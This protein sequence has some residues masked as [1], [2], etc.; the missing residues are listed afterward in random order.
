MIVGVH[1]LAGF[2]KL[3]HY[4]VPESLQAS[5]AVGALVRVPVLNQVRLGIIGEIGAPRDFPVERLKSVVQVVHPF[6]ALPP[7]LL[8][9]ARWMAGYYACGLDSIIETMIPAAVRNGAGLKQEKLLSVAQKLS[10][11]ALTALTKR[12]P[13]QARLYRFLEQQFKPQNKALVLRRL[14]ATA[15]VA[16]ASASA[17]ASASTP[18]TPNTPPDPL[19]SDASADGWARPAGQAD[20][21]PDIKALGVTQLIVPAR[22]P[23][24]DTDLQ[25]QVAPTGD[26][27]PVQSGYIDGYPLGNQGEEMQVLVDNSNNASPVLVKIYDLDRRSNVR[28]AYVLGRAKFLIDKLSAGKYEVRYQNIMIGGVR[29]ECASGHRAPLRQA[30]ARQPGA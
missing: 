14:G 1:P 7:D 29:P 25:A 15:A 9:L 27:W 16:A 8:Q 24:C 19:G 11:D 30:A 20:A 12:A 28:H 13:Q 18:N 21:P 5:A 10:A 4:R 22:A 2:D 3:L 17:S 23:D 6:P 26:P